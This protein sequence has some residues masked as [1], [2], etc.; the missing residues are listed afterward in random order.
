VGG[1]AKISDK[2]GEDIDAQPLRVGPIDLDR[3]V[4]HVRRSQ[5]RAQKD[6]DDAERD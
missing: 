1:S 2:A 3:G 5:P 4:V 6:S